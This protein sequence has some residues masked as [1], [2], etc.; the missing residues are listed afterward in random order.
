[1]VLAMSNCE[2]AML[3]QQASQ[4]GLELRWEKLSRGALETQHY[5]N[6]FVH[7]SPILSQNL[8]RKVAPDAQ[9]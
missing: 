1:M 4:Q 8:S 3:N 6:L 2:I 7:V 9:R 5:H